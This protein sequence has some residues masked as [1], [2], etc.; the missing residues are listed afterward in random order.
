M[1]TDLA[2]SIRARLLNLAKAERSDFNQMLVRFALERLL[3]RLSQSKY[4]DQFLL[5]GALLFTLWYDQP[6]RPTRDADLLG[7]GSSDLASLQ[8]IFAEVAGIP[9]NDGIAFDPSSVHADAIRKEA[10]YGGARILITGELAKARC[11]V[12]IDVGF[13]DAV[14]PAP[15]E[16]IFPILLKDMPAPALRTYPVYT[17]IAEKVHA[18]VV[19]G[20]AN[21]RL[22][23]YLDLFVLFERE[24][25]DSNMLAQALENTFQRRGMAL[26]EQLP[27][28]LTGAFANAPGKQ[29]MWQSLLRK[30]ELPITSF[31]DSLT[32]LAAEL[33]PYFVPHKR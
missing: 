17:V 22:K 33:K 20:M 8:E 19:L 11:K 14:T 12:Q 10:N 9:V 30:N 23:D 2:A 5:K 4:A 13:G 24:T 31:P 3:Y 32:M 1:S 15:V 21:T 7:F 25:L 26:P 6:H 16:A 27:A 18:I 29:R 28:G